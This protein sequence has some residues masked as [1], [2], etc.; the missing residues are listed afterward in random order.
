MCCQ[1]VA[2][3]FRK[4]VVDPALL[5]QL[6][7]RL[8]LAALMITIN[9]E[10]GPTNA[11]AADSLVEQMLRPEKQS[12]GLGFSIT[13]RD[14]LQRF[15]HSGTDVVSQACCGSARVSFPPA[16]HRASIQ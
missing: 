4:L 10:T 14:G 9:F 12:Y 13:D 7:I 1:G 8:L 5:R 2:I 16:V 6:Q 11:Y 15:S 3:Y